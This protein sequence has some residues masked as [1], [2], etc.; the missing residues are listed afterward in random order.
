MKGIRFYGILDFFPNR[1]KIRQEYEKLSLDEK[2]LYKKEV[3]SICFAKEDVKDLIWEYL[4]GWD[5]SQFQLGKE[6][7]EKKTKIEKREKNDGNY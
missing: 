2:V 1:E 3:Y 4:N 6:W 7:R 5:E